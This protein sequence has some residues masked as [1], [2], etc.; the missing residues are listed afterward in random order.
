[1]LCTF[2]FWFFSFFKVNA[3]S[4]L[5]CFYPKKKK[6]KKIYITKTYFVIFR[7]YF[8]FFFFFLLKKMGVF[9]VILHS[10]TRRQSDIGSS[11][12]SQSV[13][14]GKPSLK[15][16]TNGLL[17]AT[18][19]QLLLQHT[20]YFILYFTFLYIKIIYFLFACCYS[21]MVLQKKD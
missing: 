16:P 6:K 11:R 3:Q 5:I 1:M 7:N 2:F 15:M 20:E 4:I 13:W 21:N 10:R 17:W 9:M 19:L 18:G 8:Y 14:G 12:S